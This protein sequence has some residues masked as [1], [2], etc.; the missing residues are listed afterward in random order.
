MNLL[1]RAMEIC[2]QAHEGQFRRDGITPYSS[3]PIAV[4][5]MMDT[6]E[7]KVVALL[8]DVIE[9]TDYTYNKLY[10]LLLHDCSDRLRNALK[11]ITKQD[12]QDYSV[13]MFNI[14]CCSLA[15]KVKIADMFHNISDNPTLK[16]KE[17]YFSALKQ[18]LLA[19]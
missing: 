13:Y 9:D 2:L 7:E 5:E 12:H 16:Q 10:D 6:E 14:G 4:A 17:K 15:R 8:H 19:S 11:L 3:H 18:L 1:D